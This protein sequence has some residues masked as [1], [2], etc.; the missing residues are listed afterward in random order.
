MKK[1]KAQYGATQM[2]II[3]TFA[4]L[5][6]GC[7]IQDWNNNDIGLYAQWETEDCGVSIIFGPH[8][9]GIYKGKHWLE[10]DEPR[11]NHL[12]IFGI[13]DDYI[14]F[15]NYEDG[16]NVMYEMVDHYKWKMKN[17]KNS[18]NH[19]DLTAITGVEIMQGVLDID[20]DDGMT[21]NVSSVEDYNKIA[22][23]W[24]AKLNK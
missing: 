8:A 20:G 22:K 24:N 14:H 19:I 9:G 10:Y 2:P 21:T 16:T 15:G 7:K 11:S 6:W 1:L 12:D 23:A 13:P 4:N 3:E 18:F 5:P 17:L